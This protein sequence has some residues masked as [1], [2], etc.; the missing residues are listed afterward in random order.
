MWMTADVMLPGRHLHIA[1]LLLAAYCGLPGIAMAQNL[2]PDHKRFTLGA[3]IGG[4]FGAIIH[5]NG[6]G[7]PRLDYDASGVQQFSLYAAV[8]PRAWSRIQTGI[9]F[10]RGE[11]LFTDTHGPYTGR[12]KGS[13]SYIDMQKLITVSY[14]TVPLT[15][16]HY[17][18][19]IKSLL[20]T[21]EKVAAAEATKKDLFY[22]MIGIQAFILADGDLE[23]RKRNEATNGQWVVADIL[24]IKPVFEKFI[25]V[26]QIPDH[27]PADGRE[28]YNPL[29]FG[30]TVGFG[31]NKRLTSSLD[32]GLELTASGTLTDINSAARNPDGTYAWRFPY[33]LRGKPYAPGYLGT[34]C[35]SGVFNFHL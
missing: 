27:L 8:N 16:R 19:N 24:D 13:E 29:V 15:Y 26:D 35:L 7:F 28:L 30:V 2:L 31:W 33:Y 14:V 17:F 12:S 4:G 11:Y 25:P 20:S 18:Y 22:G 21:E 23:L 6:L 3:G 9:G 32:V 10:T 1:L 34:I 5:H